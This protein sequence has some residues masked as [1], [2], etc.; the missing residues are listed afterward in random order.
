MR[1][2]PIDASAVPRNPKGMAAQRTYTV[3]STEPNGAPYSATA[4]EIWKDKPLKA[5][6]TPSAQPAELS[7]KDRTRLRDWL[8]HTD[9]PFEVNTV[10]LSRKRKRA[11]ANQ[12]QVQDDLFQDRLAVQYEVKPR[13][14]WESL[15]KYKKFTGKR[16]CDKVLLRI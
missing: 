10:P 14:K 7:D 3:K 5:P 1:T 16:K 8:E 6:A 2:R 13:D 9:R 4:K 11:G 12:L 15:R